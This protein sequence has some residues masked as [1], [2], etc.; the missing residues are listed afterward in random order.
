MSLDDSPQTVSDNRQ[1]RRTSIPGTKMLALDE[2]EEDE[3]DLLRY[4][5]REENVLLQALLEK[6]GLDLNINYVEEGRYTALNISSQLGNL[7]A[8]KMLL[9]REDIQVGV[10]HCREELLRQQS[11]AIKNQLGHP[12]HHIR[13][14][15]T[16]KDLT[17]LS[18]LPIAGSL[19]HKSDYNRTNNQ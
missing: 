13:G 3:E 17:Y 18:C 14:F 7:P 19:W 12:K 9:L 15:G 11:Y 5:R 2:V 6:R 10:V 16:Q 8:V 4:C 1:N